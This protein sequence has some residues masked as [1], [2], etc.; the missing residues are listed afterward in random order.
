MSVE[1]PGN[2]GYGGQQNDGGGSYYP[3]SGGYVGSYQP[4]GW[5][6]YSSFNGG[7]PSYQSFTPGL[8]LMYSGDINCSDYPYYGICPDPGAAG[9]NG[10]VVTVQ[11]DGN[12]TG[13][14]T[15][16]G[17]G[18]PTTGGDTTTTTTTTTA[19]ATNP[20]L[21]AIKSL[22]GARSPVVP[23]NASG[24]AYL[25]TPG[26]QQQAAAPVITPAALIILAIVGIVG[27][28]VYKKVT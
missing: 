12:T 2:D 6:G 23:V 8:D 16:G 15:S 27:F 26:Q 22:L 7:G 13:G 25:F 17:L 3:G 18:D 24:P 5:G 4:D 14:S 9:V 1:M 28:I 20:I 21:D 11:Y 19:P 10:Q